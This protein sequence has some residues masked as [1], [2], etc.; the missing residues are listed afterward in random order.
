VSKVAAT[1]KQWLE[2]AIIRRLDHD[3]Y[4]SI[5]G[6]L[7]EPE[8]SGVLDYPPELMPVRIG[9]LDE[10][11]LGRLARC[12]WHGYNIRTIAA[13]QHIA[14]PAFRHLAG[15][16][17][18]S[19]LHR[20]IETALTYATIDEEFHTH[21]HRQAVADVEL[22]TDMDESLRRLRPHTVDALEERCAKVESLRERQLTIVAYALV[23]ELSINKVLTE[24]SSST[25][26]RSRNTRLAAWHAAD[27]AAHTAILLLIGRELYQLLDECSREYLVREILLAREVFMSTDDKLWTRY[28]NSSVKR[29]KEL[30]LQPRDD[31]YRDMGPVDIFLRKLQ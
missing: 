18:S 25:S 1:N 3:E 20:E 16:F 24:L 27:E 19:P 7:G 4:M 30:V 8:S 9:E 21:L 17:Q 26:M 28:W 22:K 6:G 2:R 13:E 31:L 11:E 10:E 23:T 29:N 12:A 15:L 5:V 14:A